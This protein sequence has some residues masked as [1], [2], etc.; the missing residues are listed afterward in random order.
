MRIPHYMLRVLNTQSAWKQKQHKAHHYTTTI[1]PNTI[2]CEV[3]TDD[4]ASILAALAAGSPSA[5]VPIGV[6]AVRRE[7]PPRA[8]LNRCG[9]WPEEFPDRRLRANGFTG[10]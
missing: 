6:T 4:A 3:Y 10:T 2:K 1:F 8:S 5:V 9:V 7:L